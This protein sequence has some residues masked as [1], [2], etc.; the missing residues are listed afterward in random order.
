MRRDEPALARLEEHLG[1]VLIVGVFVSA[2]TLAVGLALFLSTG[3][4]QGA[5]RLL[6]IGLM[7]LM[8]TPM[9]RVIVSIVEYVRMRDWFFVATTVIVLTELAIT[10]IYSLRRL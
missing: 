9:L 10:V 3:G 8:G 5:S 7:L 6:T 1:R 2:I 4:G